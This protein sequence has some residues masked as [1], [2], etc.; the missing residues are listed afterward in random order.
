MT[1]DEQ[2]PVVLAAHGTQEPSGPVTIEAVA[3]ALSERLGGRRVEVGYLDV[4]EPTV[5]QTLAALGSTAVVVP[6]LLA[7]GYHV[8][9]DLPAVAAEHDHPVERTASVGPDPR[10]VDAVLERL[11]EAG[12]QQ[13]DAIVLGAAGSS[14]PRSA[15]A[16]ARTVAELALR[17]GARVLAAYASASRPSPAEAVAQLRAEGHERVALATYLLAPGLFSERMRAA[18]A[19]VVS[20]PIGATPALLDVIVDRITAVEAAQPVG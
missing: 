6:L 19:D 16:T 5:G 11:V 10:I 3:A 18:G 8:D 13:G 17:T 4:I 2:I 1:A 7:P 9:V 20:E 15:E 12:Y 14:S